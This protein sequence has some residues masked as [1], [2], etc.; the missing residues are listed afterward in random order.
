[1]P[2][3]RAVRIFAVFLAV[4]FGYYISRWQCAS[5]G[6]LL[7]VL[8]VMIADYVYGPQPGQPLRIVAE[9]RPSNRQTGYC[10]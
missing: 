10:R 2:S 9:W 6:G 7:L 1:M 8:S 4:A 5:F 3:R